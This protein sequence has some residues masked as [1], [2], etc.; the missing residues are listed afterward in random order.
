MKY[1]MWYFLQAP[2]ND[3][4]FRCIERQKKP[5]IQAKIMIAYKKDM[6]LKIQE[7]TTYGK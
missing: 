1:Y 3:Q 7:D 2:K 4:L 6:F 5:N